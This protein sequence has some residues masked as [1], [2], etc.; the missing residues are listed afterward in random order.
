MPL[1]LPLPP[2]SSFR[3]RAVLLLSPSPHT[4]YLPLLLRRVFTRTTL[5]SMRARV[6]QV[7]NYDV[8]DS[9]H[10]QVVEL[11][12]EHAC[13]GKPLYIAVERTVTPTT[14]TREVAIKVPPSYKGEAGTIGLLVC[15]IGSLS[16]AV[17]SLLVLCLCVCV[18]V[19]VRVRVCVCVCVCASTMQHA[20]GQ[21]L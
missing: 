13:E 17:Q 19:R 10:D 21:P 8:S 7:A 5:T 3:A 18:Y 16:E 2:P 14:V 12:K 15:H 11:L 1:L 4:I 9:T 20:S 6:V